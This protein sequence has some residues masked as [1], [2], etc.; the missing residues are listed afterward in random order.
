ML[1]SVKNLLTDDITGSKYPLDGHFA[2][3]ERGVILS[4]SI[5]QSGKFNYKLIILHLQ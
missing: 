1:A 3:T 4:D 2:G 5:I